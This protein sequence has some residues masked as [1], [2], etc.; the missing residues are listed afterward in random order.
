MHVTVPYSTPTAVRFHECTR[1][2]HYYYHHHRVSPLVTT[3][4]SATLQGERVQGFT[5][6]LTS[7]RRREM[8]RSSQ[9]RQGSDTEWWEP[10]TD[11]QKKIEIQ[12]R[13]KE[14]KAAL[15]I[16]QYILYIIYSVYCSE[17]CSEFSCPLVCC[18]AVDLNLL[19][20]PC[21]QTWS[22]TIPW[23]S[24]W[25]RRNESELLN[26]VYLQE[27][28]GALFIRTNTLHMHTHAQSNV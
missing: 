14:N 22:P 19:L 7:A 28:W 4:C 16:E 27:S 17:F 25:A 21:P 5:E 20:S 1:T 3:V 18:P 11:K 24:S 26:G 2:Y 23:A 6:V 9:G 13:I 12:S 8:S 10:Q 15:H